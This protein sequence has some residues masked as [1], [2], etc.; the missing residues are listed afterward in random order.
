MAG[1][2]PK[3][4]PDHC[5]I[6]KNILAA[7]E[8][9]AAVCAEIEIAR[10]TLHEWRKTYPEFDEAI[11][12]GLQQ[13]QRVWEKEGR[14]AMFNETKYFSSSPYIFTMKN[15]FRHDYDFEKQEASPMDELLK[16]LV[17]KIVK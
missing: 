17:E 16:Q 2:K 9:L 6:A 7:G 3:Y 14:E 10:S 15:R 11:E 5:E 1:A 4:R 13:C 12:V 8:S